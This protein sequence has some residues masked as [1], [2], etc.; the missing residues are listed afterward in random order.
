MSIFTLARTGTY[1][2]RFPK[3]CRPCLGRRWGEA[4]AKLTINSYVW[5]G[6][7]FPN[8]SRVKHRN[9]VFRQ[10]GAWVVLVDNP[11]FPVPLGLYIAEQQPL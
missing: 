5:Q 1:D 4:G 11:R 2:G 7:D 9:V 8:L 10:E 6:G 3:S